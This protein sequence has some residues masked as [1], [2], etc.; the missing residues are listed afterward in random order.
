[1]IDLLK[2]IE[3]RLDDDEFMHQVGLLMKKYHKQ[4]DDQPLSKP[5]D[6][7]ATWEKVI[8]D[9]SEFAGSKTIYDDEESVYN[10]LISLTQAIAKFNSISLS[11]LIEEC[12]K[13]DEL[14]LQRYGTRLQPFNG[15]DSI[16]DAFQEI[17]DLLVYM[18]NV[19]LEQEMNNGTQN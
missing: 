11:E 9:L 16:K 6:L 17:L 7:P 2:Q 4:N 15:R 19:V 1:M 3:D 8:F 12:Y 13:R 14:G 10:E 5:N 18:K